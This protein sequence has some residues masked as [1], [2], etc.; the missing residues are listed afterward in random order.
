MGPLKQLAHWI[1]IAVIHFSSEILASDVLIIVIQCPH[2]S[3]TVL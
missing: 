1:I 2:F 3:H